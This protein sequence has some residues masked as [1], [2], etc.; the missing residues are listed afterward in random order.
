LNALTQLF[1]HASPLLIY[2]LVAVLL[3]LES[4]GIP[5]VNST[6]LLF[7]G[8]LST[9]LHLNIWVLVAA[10][11]VGSTTGACLA[12][13]IGLWGGRKIL[14]RLLSLFHIDQQKVSMTERW[15]QQSGIW[16][17]FFSRMIPYVRPFACFPAGISRM[18]FGRFLI[19]ASVGSLIWCVMMLQIGLALGH[20]WRFAFHLI[21]NY[22]IPTLCAL[23]IL[24]ALY[25]LITYE[26]RRLLHSRLQSAA[27][28]L[29]NAGEPG[30]CDPVEV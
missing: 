29:D 21:Q 6:L 15:F 5:V 20:R 12:Y 19:A 14:L 11:I 2:L 26:V 13:V 25:F 10:A 3:F 27:G 30:T 9:L 17:I 7:T 23:A 28:P 22:T 18:P 24:V 1:F 4:S 16:M 8:A